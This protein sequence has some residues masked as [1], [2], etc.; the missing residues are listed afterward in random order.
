LAAVELETEQL[1]VLGQVVAGVGI[2]D[3]VV[4]MEMELV[5]GTLYEDD[6]TEYTM[7]KWRPVAA[8]TAGGEA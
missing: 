3:L 6:D 5:L 8:S 4:G 7:W 1:V 2:E